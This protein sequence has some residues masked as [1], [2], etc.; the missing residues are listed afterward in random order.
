[1]MQEV[2]AS[3][4][5]TSTWA[6]GVQR[7]RWEQVPKKRSDDP[8]H[9]D[10]LQAQKQAP[11][12][13]CSSIAQRDNTRSSQKFDGEFWRA[14]WRADCLESTIDQDVQHWLCAPPCRP[15]SING[16]SDSAGALQGSTQ[17]ELD[18]KIGCVQIGACFEPGAQ[19]TQSLA[20][21]QSS[22]ANWLVISDLRLV[23][24]ATLLCPE[25]KTNN[26]QEFAKTPRTRCMLVCEICGYQR[27]KE[28]NDVVR[29]VRDAAWHSD[30]TVSR[31]STDASPRLHAQ[32]EFTGGHG[33]WSQLENLPQSR[34][35]THL[36]E[37]RGTGIQ[38]GQCSHNDNPLLVK[39][40]LE[41]LMDFGNSPVK[42]RHK[43]RISAPPRHSE[44]LGLQK[45][46]EAW[47]QR[48]NSSSSETLGRA[49]V[50][51]I[52]SAPRSGAKGY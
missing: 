50:C 43:Q 36:R 19:A 20:P 32:A 40:E 28:T 7:N 21:D 14:F 17:S 13:A 47:A 35:T 1:M 9:I 30:E 52:V 29:R 33:E 23:R 49:R 38:V 12:H 24:V 41:L 51:A 18:R 15:F 11:R 4:E 26:E 25:C 34:N 48:V 31:A 16:T 45:A 8:F 37:N 5:S 3:H 10:P 2:W 27:E 6:R 39:R 44:D 42:E 22:V 46:L